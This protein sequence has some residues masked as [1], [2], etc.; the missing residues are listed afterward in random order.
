MVKFLAE[1]LPIHTRH[2]FTAFVKFTNDLDVSRGQDFRAL[3]GELIKGFAA[4]GL[5]W[6]DETAYAKRPG[7]T[8]A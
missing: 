7:V 4:D 2:D 8:A 6:T 3:Y 5:E 1:H